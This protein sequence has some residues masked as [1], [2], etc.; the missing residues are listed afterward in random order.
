MTADETAWQNAL[1]AMLDGEEPSM[2]ATAVL[3]HLEACDACSRWL[4]DA[5][6]LGSN[7]HLLPVVERDLGES[8]VNGI[9]VHLCACR[10]GGACLC[11]DCQCGPGCTCQ[12]AE[13]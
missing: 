2:D 8:L 11:G 12:P 4:A 9:D 10:S 3:A 13:A 6:A 1:S 5:T 7:L